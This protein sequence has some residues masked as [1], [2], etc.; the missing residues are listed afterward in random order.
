MKINLGKT[1]KDSKYLALIKSA[2][3]SDHPRNHGLQMQ[4]HHIISS[5]GMKRSGQAKRIEKIGYNINHLPNLVFIPCTLQG[6][7]YLGVQPHRGNHS[8]TVDQD[9]YF[10]D[11]EPSDYHD[12][13]ADRVRDL[14]R[15]ILK[16]CL[17]TKEERTA[18]STR[19]LNELSKQILSLIQYKPPEA[20]LTKIAKYFGK[21]QAGCSGVDTVS[22]HKSSNPCPVKHNHLFNEK[23]PLDSQGINQKVE[24]IRFKLAGKYKLKPGA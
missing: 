23:L 17:G 19:Q 15:R 7:C 20:P 13:V 10:D 12:M 6:A 8:A 1:S 16:E 21:G 4:A 5:E 11:M 2:I 22:S 24:K 3:N 9:D 14:T 18:D